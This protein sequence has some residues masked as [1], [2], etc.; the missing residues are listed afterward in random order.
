MRG[1]EV[2]PPRRRHTQ[3]RS[4]FPKGRQVS[5]RSDGNGPRDD[6]SRRRDSGEGMSRR[7]NAV[8]RPFDNS[9]CGKGRRGIRGSFPVKVSFANLFILLRHKGVK[10][11][12]M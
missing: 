10:K 1:A 11:R 6:G 7:G 4:P 12:L 2:A 9:G 8:S 5:R 3:R